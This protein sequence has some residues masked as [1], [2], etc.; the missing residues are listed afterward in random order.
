MGWVVNATP[1][2]L[3]LRGRDRMPIVQEAGWATEQ[4]WIGAEILSLLK[5]DPRT[6][7]IIASHYSDYAIWAQFCT[8]PSTIRSCK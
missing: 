2:S 1:H 8:S 6:V 3:Y 4:V 7:Q 5:F